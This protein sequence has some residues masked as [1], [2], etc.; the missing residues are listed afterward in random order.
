MGFSAILKILLAKIKI[1]FIKNHIQ[2]FIEHIDKTLTTIELQIIR[3]LKLYNDNYFFTK[4]LETK[5]TTKSKVF[6]KQNYVF[7]FGI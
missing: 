4:H 2:S 1:N 3:V 7:I 5:V 6:F